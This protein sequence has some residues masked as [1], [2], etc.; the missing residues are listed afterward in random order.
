MHRGLY[1]ILLIQIAMS[2]NL[3][4]VGG[5]ELVK[6]ND[7]ILYN[8]VWPF[9]LLLF[10]YKMKKAPLLTAQISTFLGIYPTANKSALAWA[11]CT[12]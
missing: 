6:L 1:P 2:Y 8:I 4:V 5:G 11:S 3:L 10:K 9:L 12:D 7:L